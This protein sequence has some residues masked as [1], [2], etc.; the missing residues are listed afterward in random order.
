MI[1]RQLFQFL[2]LLLAG[3]VAPGCHEQPQQL[4]VSEKIFVKDRKFI[5]AADH[6]APDERL[7]S[8]DTVGITCYGQYRPSDGYDTTQIKL[9]WSYDAITP[10]TNF[11][12]VIETDSM[13]WSHPPRDGQYRILELNPFPYIKLPAYKGQRWNWNLAVG[14]WWGDKQW[15]IWKGDILVTSIYQITGQQ[16]ISTPF[17]QLTCWVVQAQ[18]T[19]KKGT[20]ALT[21]FYHPRYG[22]VRLAYCNINSSRVTLNLIAVTTVSTLPPDGFLPD[23]LRGLKSPAKQ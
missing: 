3:A 10:P 23:A 7:F 12:G 21:I 1:F 22:F 13:L 15:V 20:S 16:A 4:P 14:D 2:L 17:G 8:R 6:F 9:G 5:Y 18:A 19:C 11:S